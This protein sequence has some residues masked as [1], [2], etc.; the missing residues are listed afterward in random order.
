L[1]LSVKST[2]NVRSAYAGIE[3]SITFWV[4]VNVGYSNLCG[5]TPKRPLSEF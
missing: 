3:R 1:L 5:D 4:G 2:Q